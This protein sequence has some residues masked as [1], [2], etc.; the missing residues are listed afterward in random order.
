[1]ALRRVGNHE[2]DAGGCG[3][4]GAARLA[5]RA[6]EARP[7]VAVRPHAVSR[8]GLRDHAAADAGRHGDPVFR[9][10]HAALSR[11]ARARG[12]ADRRSAAPVD[13]TWLLRPRAQ[14]A[15]RRAA[16]ARRARRRVP[17]RVRAVAALPG[18]GRSTAGAILALATGQRH[19]ILDGNV[20]RVLARCFGVEGSAAERVVEQRL[21][22]LAERLHAGRSGV[23]TYTQAIMDLGATVCTHRRPSCALCPLAEGCRA[24]RQRPP[25]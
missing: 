3:R 2:R 4:A 25:A 20:R 17:A 1:M 10:L 23:D 13:R 18:I 16:S 21:W 19:A 8:L 22:A 9:A 24:R 7:A 15:S 6:R 12:R 14:P 11:C 5:R